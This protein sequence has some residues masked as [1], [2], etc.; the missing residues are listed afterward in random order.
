M[1]IDYLWLYQQKILVTDG[2]TASPNTYLGKMLESSHPAKDFLHLLG[3]I[4]I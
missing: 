3:A 4:L 2:N 1:F